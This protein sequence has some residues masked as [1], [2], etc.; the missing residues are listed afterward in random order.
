VAGKANDI[1]RIKMPKALDDLIASNLSAY[2]LPDRTRTIVLNSLTTS[3]KYLS[4]LSSQEDKLKE[5]IAQKR[6]QVS[7]NVVELRALQVKK[8]DEIAA[9][10]DIGLLIQPRLVQ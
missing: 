6:A 2:D 5:L 3:Q 10:Q 4:N 8:A 9:V 1:G 7:Q